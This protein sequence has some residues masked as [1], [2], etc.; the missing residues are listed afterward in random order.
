MKSSRVDAPIVEEFPLTLECKVAEL[1]HTAYGFRVLGEIVNVL[2]ED[3][4]LDEKGRVDP[5]KLN[6]FVFD[7]F[8]NG[9]YKIGEKCGQAWSSGAGLM[10]K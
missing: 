3:R 9:Y 2:A 4:V 8:Q 7:Q 5:T 10:K 1:Q 6:A